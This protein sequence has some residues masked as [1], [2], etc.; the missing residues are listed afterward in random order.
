MFALKIRKIGNS[1]GV[2]FPKEALAGMHVS[3][4]D[5]LYL[6]RTPDGFHIT[7][8]D[9]EFATQMELAEKVMKEDREVLRALASK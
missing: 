4:G 2:V 6:T 1:E 8:Y 7:P 5:I 3:S 9:K